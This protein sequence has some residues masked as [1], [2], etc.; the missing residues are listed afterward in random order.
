M[1]YGNDDRDGSTMLVTIGPKFVNEAKRISIKAKRIGRCQGGGKVVTAKSQTGQSW[2]NIFFLPLKKFH[3]AQFPMLL[4]FPLSS[5]VQL[6]RII[7]IDWNLNFDL[8][9][10]GQ[11]P[12]IMTKMK[13][14]LL[15]PFSHR[16]IKNMKPR[17]VSVMAFIWKITRWVNQCISHSFASTSPRNH[18]QK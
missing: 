7:C 12:Q 5:L 2:T 1:Y 15:F 9:R 16:Q 3:S 6:Q 13:H 10:A 14:T 4:Q 18:L 8:T 17:N 11:Y